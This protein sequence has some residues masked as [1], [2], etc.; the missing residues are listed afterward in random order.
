MTKKNSTAKAKRIMTAEEFDRHFDEGGEIL[1]MMDLSKA[2]SPGQDIKR[3]NVDFPLR[4]LG[5]LD[6]HAARMGVT[7]QSVI[8]VWIAERL[9]Q[10]ELASAPKEF[11]RAAPRAH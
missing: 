5:S 6:Q 8:K 2:H 3:V 9:Q 11:P 10:E 7:R 1:S 4:I